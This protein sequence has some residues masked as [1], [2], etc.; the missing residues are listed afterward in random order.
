MVLIVLHKTTT[1]PLFVSYAKLQVVGEERKINICLLGSA[2]EVSVP[3]L[4]K[5]D[6]NCGY[7][8]IVPSSSVVETSYF[9]DNEGWANFTWFQVNGPEERLFTLTVQ[10]GLMTF[11]ALTGRG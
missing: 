9:T 11:T 7:E 3:V 8:W 4:G 2:A 10:T 6:P 5:L 1:Y